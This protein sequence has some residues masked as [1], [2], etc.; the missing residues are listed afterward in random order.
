MTSICDISAL[1]RYNDQLLFLIFL[2][3]Q[4][5]ILKYKI[6]VKWNKDVILTRGPL[7]FELCFD[8]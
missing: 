3:E 5:V 1:L 2:L 7:N 8:V 4:T 6:F